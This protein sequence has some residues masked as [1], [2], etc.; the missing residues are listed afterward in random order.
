LQKSADLSHVQPAANAAKS[1]ATVFLNNF[2]MI[3]KV[4]HIATPLPTDSP[5]EAVI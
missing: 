4:Y 5:R 1:A 2:F 3:I